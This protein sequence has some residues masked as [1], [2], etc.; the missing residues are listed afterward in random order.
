MMDDYNLFRQQVDKVLSQQK[1]MRLQLRNG[2][3]SST[4]TTLLTTLSMLI[5]VLLSDVIVITIQKMQFY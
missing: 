5:D 2:L 3:Y 1:A 4:C